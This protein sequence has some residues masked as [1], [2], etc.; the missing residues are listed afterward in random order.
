MPYIDQYGIE[1]EPS[2]IKR[3]T[4]CAMCERSGDPGEEVVCDLI[5]LAQAGSLL[6]KCTSFVSLY[7]VLIDDIII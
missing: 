7:G 6:F 1:T 4:F 5:R 3:P 2:E